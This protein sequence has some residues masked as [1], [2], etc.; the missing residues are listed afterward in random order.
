MINHMPLSKQE[1]ACKIEQNSIKTLSTYANVR[2]VTFVENDFVAE[3]TSCFQLCWLNNVFRAD[4]NCPK[5]SERVTQ[6]LSK[7]TKR[8]PMLW[9]IGALTI[10][11]EAVKEELIKNGLTYLGSE[12]GMVL[13]LNDFQYSPT[14]PEFT[15]RIVAT[16]E[17]LK[18][19]L[20]IFAE[21]FSLS[22]DV[23]KYFEQS[24]QKRLGSSETEVWF[25]GYV[26]DSP[27]CTAACSINSGISLIS[28]V[29]TRSPFR[30]RGYARR[31]TEAA[32]NYATKLYP[33]PIALHSETESKIYQN[34]G[35]SPVYNYEQYLYQA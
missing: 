11:P 15:V 5:L 22:E 21:V 9:R 10:N 8:C 31:I 19:W 27:V 3:F 17:E 7:Y 16:Q 4:G 23:A 12:L 14:I 28:N 2:G 33:Y 20:V 6:T 35:F 24:I 30:K 13:D 29:G 25:I 32:I 18:D 34:M 26:D 1:L